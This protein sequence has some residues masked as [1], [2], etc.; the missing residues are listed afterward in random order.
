MLVSPNL[1]SAGVAW[2]K[3]MLVSQLKAAGKRHHFSFADWS[4]I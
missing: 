2:H 3:A 1:R 4:F